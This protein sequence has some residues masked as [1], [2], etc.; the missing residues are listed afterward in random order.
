MF[1]GLTTGMC[2]AFGAGILVGAGA[3]TWATSCIYE[4]IMEDDSPALDL[5]PLLQ[6]LK[7]FNFAA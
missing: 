4:S 6:G 1:T 5:T 7:N 3:G 2:V